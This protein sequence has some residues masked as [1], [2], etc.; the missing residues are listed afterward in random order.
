MRNT[1]IY[2]E[3]ELLHKQGIKNVDPANVSGAL[4]GRENVYEHL[5]SMFNRA[6]KSIFL[7]TSANGLIRKND[8]Y[9]KQFKK[10][11][12]SGVKIKI[13][14]P[15]T[16]ENDE[17]V[18][19]LKEVADVKNI[20]RINARFAVIDNKEVVFMMNDDAEVHESYDVGIWASSPFFAKAMGDMFDVSWTKVEA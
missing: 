20:G 4:K 2:T 3:L 19:S 6:E 18:K 5:R 11:K 13:I 16:K 17:A 15:F 12:T 7:V 9:K 14:S 1:E 8:L 10:L